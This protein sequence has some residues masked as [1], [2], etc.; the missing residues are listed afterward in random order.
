MGIF[1]LIR[2]EGTDYSYLKKLYKKNEKIEEIPQNSY[3][4]KCLNGTF[5]GKEKENV[6]SYKGI[7]YAKPPIKN[8]R[9]KP[10]V[11][12]DNSDD[13][14]EAFAFQKSSIQKRGEGEPA[15]FYEIGEDCLYLNIWKNNDNVKNKPVMVFIH[16]GAFAWGGPADPTY[17]GH[18][19][20]RDHKDVIFVTIA[21]R[22]SIL[23]FLDLT[24]IK[25]G[26]NYKESPN[27]G[28][29]D[30]I[31]ALRWINKN[32]EYFGGDKNNVTIIGESAGATS[33][34]TL[35]LIKGT[36][37]LFKRIISQ[38][39]TFG[40]TVSKEDG[41]RVVEILRNEIKKKRQ[42]ELDVDYLLSLSEEEMITLN[43]VM[44]DY[45]LPP[46]R[47]GYII[48]EDCYG[49]VERGAYDGIDLM[50]GSNAD[51]IKYYRVVFG[52]FFKMAIQLYLENIIY[53]RIKKGGV[54]LFNEYKKH[55]ENPVENF[56]NDLYFRSSA[57]KIAQIHSKNKGN[58]YLYYWAHP[59]SLPGYGACH[60]CELTYV[61]DNLHLNKDFGDKNV[62][63][64]LGA[65]AQNMWVNFA[66][67]GDPSTKEI[68]WEKYDEKNSYCMVFR[69]EP[70]LKSHIFKK[71][72]DDLMSSLVESYIPYHCAELS[73]NVPFIKKGILIF[74]AI[75]VLIIS[76]LFRKFFTK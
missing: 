69:D 7:P 72:R 5:V 71:E 41:K 40:L 63:Y 53:Y 34:T 4:V 68:K 24:L 20:I 75:F 66:K 39:G 12:C 47:D 14:Y 52:S 60:A 48:P 28:L 55:V 22:V 59:Y 6:I 70:E 74:L 43:H 3:P 42:E 27:L 50:I 49:E 10:P 33:V 73:L 64:K 76:V 15:S 18:N 30:Q 65:E 1:Y 67:C 16:G 51:E 19:Y 21:Y 31:Q 37:G 62:N 17:D 46:V 8:L 44:N 11:E 45:S 25:G 61:L 32:I 36:K 13:I 57:L 23:G 56:L 58:V 9:W 38:S 26:E 29:L 35:P 2:T 54:E